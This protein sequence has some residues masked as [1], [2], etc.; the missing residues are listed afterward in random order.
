MEALHNHNTAPSSDTPPPTH[1]KVLSRAEKR[2]QERLKEE[3]EAT[4][5]QLTTKF[6][7]YF[8]QCTDPEGQDVVDMMQRID[9]QWRL[10]CTRKKLIPT[11]YSYH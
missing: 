9:I 1:E 7:D 11:L 10:Y 6:L 5:N 2:A 3:V 8:T 4:Y